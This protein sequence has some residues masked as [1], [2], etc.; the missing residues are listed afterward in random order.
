[1]VDGKWRGTEGEGGVKSKGRKSRTSV[2]DKY[3][4]K[5]KWTTRKTGKKNEE[6]KLFKV[7][8]FTRGRCI[9]VTMLLRAWDVYWTHGKVQI[10]RVFENV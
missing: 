4:K 7:L 1:M 9:W 3:Y 8:L 5:L 10:L 6:K 2:E